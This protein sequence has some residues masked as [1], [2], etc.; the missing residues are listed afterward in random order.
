METSK[1]KKVLLNNFY[2]IGLFSFFIIYYLIWIKYNFHS[3]T[4][5]TNDLETAVKIFNYKPYISIFLNNIFSSESLN[6]FFGYCFF[7]SL[8]SVLLFLIFKKI[9]ANNIWSLSLTFLSISA[10]ENYPFHKFLLS[11]V[12]NMNIKETINTYENFEIMGFPIPAFSIFFFCLV[13]YLTLKSIKLSRAKIYFITFLWLIMFHIHPVDGLIGNLYWIGLIGILFL[14]KKVALNKRDFLILFGIYFLNT[15]ILINQLSFEILII[16][17]SQTISLYSIIFY[18]LVPLILIFSC[19]SLLKI[20][21]Y[22]F[23]QKFLNIYLMML[24]EIILIVLSINGIGFELQMLENRITM[25]LLHFLYYMPI[26]Y[27]LSKD[28]I[29]YINTTNKSSFSGRVVILFYYI[30]NK[31][32]NLYLFAFTFL[33]VAFFVLSIKI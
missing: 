2:P 15:F 17:N 32:K 6:L 30:F 10:S 19:L 9:L 21:L 12:S 4:F 27:Y 1:I 31:Y 22:E 16:K 3:V 23:S 25:F 28:E 29:F 8:I 13:F 24:V 20:D 5:N 33:I 14:Q 26:I 18:F 11:F 7:P